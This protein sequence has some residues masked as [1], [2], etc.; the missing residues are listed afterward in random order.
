MN[1]RKKISEEIYFMRQRKLD[2]KVIAPIA[3]ATSITIGCSLFGTNSKVISEAKDYNSGLVPVEHSTVVT[4][5]AIEDANFEHQIDNVI[6]NEGAFISMRAIALNRIRTKNEQADVHVQDYIR[7]KELDELKKEIKSLKEDKKE[8]KKELRKYEEAEKKRKEKEHKEKTEIKKLSLDENNVK[9][10]SGANAHTLNVLLE[11]TYLEGYGELF[12]DLEQQHG[13]NALF[14]IGNSILETGWNGDNWLAR[15]N[16]NIYGLNTN[17]YFDSK[18]DCIRYWY[19]LLSEHYVGIGLTSMYDINDKYCPPNNQWADDIQNVVV[20]LVN[21][22][23]LT[24][25]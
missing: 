24:L 23:N 10:T 3:I 12:Y 21:K 8:L 25:N 14:S 1:L 16:N 15:N 17:R 2:K 9:K 6:D 20:R 11:G 18:E 19:D 7:H 4:P 5:S 13:I 22:N